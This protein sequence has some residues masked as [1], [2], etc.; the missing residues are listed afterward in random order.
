MVRTY[1][2]ISLLMQTNTKYMQHYC[3]TLCACALCD[4]T[5]LQLPVVALG[6]PSH[7]NNK[8]KSQLNFGLTTWVRYVVTHQSINQINKSIKIRKTRADIA[9]RMWALT[10]NHWHRPILKMIHCSGLKPHRNDNDYIAKDPQHPHLAR[11]FWHYSKIFCAKLIAR[12][13]KFDRWK[14]D[15]C[16]FSSSTKMRTKT[17]LYVA[18]AA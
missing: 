3:T 1:Y 12:S 10:K 15:L 5:G 13:T 7:N 11:L 2:S 6:I 4:G 9:T 17:L 18:T 14:E 8:K 16:G